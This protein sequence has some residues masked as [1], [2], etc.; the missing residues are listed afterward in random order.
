MFYKV[1]WMVVKLFILFMFDIYL[2]W[3]LLKWLFMN[4]FMLDLKRV[5]VDKNEK[6][7]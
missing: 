4:V 2:L 5:V 7:I 1:G 6:I 3:M